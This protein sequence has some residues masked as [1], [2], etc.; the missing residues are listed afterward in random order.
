MR[1]RPPAT[2]RQDKDP[3]ATGCAAD[4]ITPSSK[5][6]SGRKL[7]LRYSPTCR[8]AWGRISNGVSG[9]YVSVHSSSGAEYWKGIPFGS[10]STYT[11]MVNDAG[12]IAWACTT[13]GSDTC[14][15]VY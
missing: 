13:V 10:T 7:E 2:H 6:I 1:L 8:A 11:T 15:G 4:A 12:L 5:T 3:Q 9:D 14:T